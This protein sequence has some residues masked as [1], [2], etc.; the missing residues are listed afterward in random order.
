MQERSRLQHWQL[1]RLFL[2]LYDAIVVALSYFLALWLRFDLEYTAI[3]AKYIT[4]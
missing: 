2:F 1:I 4:S 3:P